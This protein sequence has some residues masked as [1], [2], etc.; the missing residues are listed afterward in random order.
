[1]RTNNNAPTDEAAN[2]E[3]ET[4]EWQLWWLNSLIF[5]LIIWQMKETKK[6]QWLWQ[7]SKKDSTQK[8][9]GQW[10]FVHFKWQRKRDIC[11]TTVLARKCSGRT[12]ISH[13]KKGESSGSK[14]HFW[15]TKISNHTI[16]FKNQL[17]G[18]GRQQKQGA[19]E[20]MAHG[21]SI[22]SRGW[23]AL[24]FFSKAFQFSHMAIAAIVS[25]KWLALFDCV[26]DSVQNK[27]SL[28][29]TISSSTIY[30]R[31]TDVFSLISSSTFNHRFSS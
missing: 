11:P 8:N 25:M 3:N 9:T 17:E 23:I 7:F 24:N 5:W 4:D 14:W 19:I 22:R 27:N 13:C 28:D 12:F 10:D 16:L 21:I 20:A 6:M 2:E 18:C 1:M 30:P 29:V 15:H 31:C 26:R